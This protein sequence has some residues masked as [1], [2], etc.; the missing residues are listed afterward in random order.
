[1]VEELKH[2]QGQSY[3]K[4]K[5]VGEIVWVIQSET[6]LVTQT[7]AQWTVNGDRGQDGDHAM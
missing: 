1:M 3:K 5:M 2:L 4:Q 7:V 6:S